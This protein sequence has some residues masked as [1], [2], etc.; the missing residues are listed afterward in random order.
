MEDL[1]ERLSELELDDQQRQRMKFFL[2]QK[3]KLGRLDEEDFQNLGDLGAGNGGVV[4][5]VIH[6]S[7]GLI[8]AKKVGFRSSSYLLIYK[9]DQLTCV[10]LKIHTGNSCRSKTSCKEADYS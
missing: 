3:Q 1:E 10:F 2:C 6:E 9:R 8:M 5:K 4:M 7:T